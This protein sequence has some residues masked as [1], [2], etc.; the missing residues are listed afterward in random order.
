MN[1][2]WHYIN[3]FCLW[4]NIIMAIC[5]FIIN[6]KELLIYNIICALFCY[7]VL[8]NMGKKC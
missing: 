6:N 5:N 3:V 8:A 4:L 1:K 7:W 2:I